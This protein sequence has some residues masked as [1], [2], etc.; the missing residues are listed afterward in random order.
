MAIS[1]FFVSPNDAYE[2]TYNLPVLTEEVFRTAVLPVTDSVG[3]KFVPLFMTGFELSSLDAAAVH[4]E[5]LLIS[6]RLQCP[7]EVAT[8]VSTRLKHLASE[9]VRIFDARQD[10]LL[11]IG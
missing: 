1:A 6:D 8:H 10:A 3:A 2:E 9:I 5:L 11:Y 7:P 4:D